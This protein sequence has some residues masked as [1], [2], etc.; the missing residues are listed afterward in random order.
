MKNNEG[1]SQTN[2]WFQPSLRLLALSVSALF[3]SAC[4]EVASLPF[5]AVSTV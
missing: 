2:G 3:L 5:S 1:L 4:G